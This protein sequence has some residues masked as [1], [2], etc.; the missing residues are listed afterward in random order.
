MATSLTA[1]QAEAYLLSKPE[2]TL[3]FPFGDDIKVFKVKTR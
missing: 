1:E 2:S 3:D